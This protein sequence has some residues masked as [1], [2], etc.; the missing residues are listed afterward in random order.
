[1]KFSQQPDKKIAADACRL[2]ALGAKTGEEA[3]NDR[4]QG[5]L[6][7]VTS[8][9]TREDVFER[10]VKAGPCGSMPPRV[11]ASQRRF[12]KVQGGF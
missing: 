2:V 11:S 5:N 6:S 1:M 8:A 10:T 9:A 3:L 4:S 12:K 7:L